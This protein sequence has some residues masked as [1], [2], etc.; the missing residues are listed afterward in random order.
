MSTV[1]G[2]DWV[3]RFLGSD[4][5]LNRLRMAT[6]TVVTISAV[7]VAERLFVG[8]TG[9]LQL[10]DSGLPPAAEAAANHQYLV[11]GMLLGAIVGMIS[12]FGVMDPTARGQLVTML[13]L[14][15]PM[16]ASLT[17]GL[18]TGD[19]RVLSLALLVAALVVGT[20]LR[21]FGPR[22]LLAGLL[23]FMGDFFGFFLHGGIGLGDLGWLLAEMLV[24]L[25]VAMG[26]RFA[27]FYPRPA[28]AL[29][30]TERSY[31]A[32]ARK[33]TAMALAVLDDR[34]HTTHLNAQLVRLNE[35]ALMI[36][37]QLGNSA[38]VSEGDSAQRLHQR[39]F[40]VELA[41]TN[42]ARFAQ[43]MS[44]MALPAEQLAAVRA[45]LLGVIGRDPASAKVHASALIE[46]L[47]VGAA[48]SADARTQTVV[49][50]RFA[51][52]VNALADAIAGWDQLGRAVDT[53]APAFSPSV[54][55]FGG[56]L[57]GTVGISAVASAERGTR[58]GD[59][60][61][62][63]PYTR[64]AIQMAVAIGSAIALGD[65]LSGK[66]FYWAVIAAFVTFL[67]A[68]TAGEQVRKA[69]LRV[70]GTVIG[71]ALGSA[72]V[73]A[74]GDHA[75]VSLGVIMVA[76]FLAFYLMRVNYAFLVIGVTVMVSQL[77]VQLD[78][79]SGQLLVLRLEETA[80]GAAVAMATV[81]LV[82]PLRTLR[83]LRVAMRHYVEALT[84]MVDH[85]TSRL[86]DGPG[87]EDLRAD[88]RALD[89]A[90]QVVVATTAPLRGE[91][92]AGALR[93]AS[94]SRN[95]VRNLVIDVEASAP[96]DPS[97]CHA[98]RTGRVALLSS[99]AVLS[100]AMTGPRTSP[101]VRS[102]SLFDAAERELER[103]QG[104]IGHAQL[105]LRDLALLDGALASLGPVMGLPVTDLDTSPVSAQVQH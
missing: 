36:D 76:L 23:L 51:V 13:L 50:H 15:F 98:V 33:T 27:L 67:G 1:P 81:V 17:L 62:L 89:A 53:D 72:I 14:P 94:A 18:A 43:A 74:T 105:A 46:M 49:L 38:A 55:L 47:Q 4:P 24:G 30:R 63:A 26:V 54:T 56:W 69:G 83:V 44:T 82:L 87:T 52:S 91:R 28:E 32:R 85:A 45:S 73:S 19:H 37:A 90:Y 84:T 86:V 71:I 48:T 7:L 5:G 6:Q 3:D 2:L 20:Y 9:A 101:Y 10:H 95:Y 39:L 80:I 35:A 104:S 68:N 79:F 16:L 59:R 75:Y 8:W 41:V 66:R 99:L 11:V 21:R 12:T 88:A 77:Y 34:S 58:R 60:I 93:V 42:V 22:G 100:Q 102:A 65:L 97:T 92:V 70:L 103:A 64:A 78:E 61:A 25:A 40:D 31:A 57:P 29:R 96:L